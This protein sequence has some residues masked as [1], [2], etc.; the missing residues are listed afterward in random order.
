MNFQEAIEKREGDILLVRQALES[1]TDKMRQIRPTVEEFR[2]LNEEVKTLKIELRKR[3]GELNTV[4]NFI[5][6]MEPS[7]GDVRFP[8]FARTSENSEKL[9]VN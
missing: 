7:L 9:G 1:I 6:E 4:L 3:Q 8:L 2:K 5:N